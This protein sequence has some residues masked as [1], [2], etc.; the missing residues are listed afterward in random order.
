MSTDF[1]AL[2]SMLSPFPGTTSGWFFNAF[3]LIIG[4]LVS[5]YFIVKY[6]GTKSRQLLNSLP[7]MWT[8]LGI[9]GT[10]MAICISLGEISATNSIAKE[11]MTLGQIAALGGAGD[12]D[13]KRIISD[14]IPAF[15]TS[16][17][18]LIAA[19]GITIYSKVLYAKEDSAID[20]RINNKTPEEYIYD[21]ANAISEQAIQNKQYNER[22]N[23]SING[24]SKILETFVNS[25]VEKMDDIFKGMGKSIKENITE[26]GEMQFKNSSEVLETVVKKMSDSSDKLM[27]QQTASMSAIVDNTN[28]EISKISKA[29]SD[30]IATINKDSVEIVKQVMDAQNTTIESAVNN[31][32]ERVKELSTTF[33]SN[34]NA[35]NTD[36]VKAISDMIFALKTQIQTI[37]DSS[38]QS[39]SNISATQEEKLSALVTNH[40]EFTTQIMAST[41]EMNKQVTDDIRTSFS[42]LVASIQTSIKSQCDALAS[43]IIDNTKLLKENYEF[44]ASHIALIRTNYE[45]ASLAYSGAVQNAHDYNESI[46]QK[47][48]ALDAS[49]KV[50]NTTNTNVS[51][52]AEVVK[53]RYEKIEHLITNINEMSTAIATLQ[54]LES[55]LN[56]INQKV[57]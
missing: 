33:T 27:S 56:K 3:V 43:S 34:I 45:Q 20:A 15:S 40:N 48:K 7:G 4:I 44:V 25:F 19:F 13:I 21:I 11:G 24:Q 16:I 51:E 26:F 6:R 22:L 46:E 55:Q 52:I 37:T 18:G 42:T 53:E 28:N 35:F 41:T 31:T 17:W 50:L 5:T 12:V 32:N 36:T 47:V 39:I 1:S 10:F 29:L 38:V 9:L 57:A 30:S 23:D 2:L 54:K 14:L 49:L 8:S